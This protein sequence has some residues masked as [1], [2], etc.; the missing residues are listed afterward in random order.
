MPQ[1][2]YNKLAEIKKN[3]DAH[4]DKIQI[5]FIKAWVANSNGPCN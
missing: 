4:A 3:N 2:V 1:G 5:G